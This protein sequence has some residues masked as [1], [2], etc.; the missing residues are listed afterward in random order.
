MKNSIIIHLLSGGMLSIGGIWATIS[1]ILYLVKDRPF[2]WI[3]VWVLAAGI[4]LGIINFIR[5]VKESL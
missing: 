4:I 2:D 1:F 3:S 5:M